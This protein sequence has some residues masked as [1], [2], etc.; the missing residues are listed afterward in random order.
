MRRWLWSAAAASG[1]LA[2]MVSCAPQ[3][4]PVPP[5]LPD[6]PWSRG[7]VLYGQ[8][9]AGC[10]GEDG[11]GSEDRPALAPLRRAPAAG[12]E[13]KTAFAT[14]ADLQAYVRANMP[15]LEAGS[16]SDDEAWALTTYLLRQADIA[17]PAELTAKNAAQ[18]KI[19]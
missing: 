4:D 17:A 15:P 7:V 6:D 3:W 13:R 16:L 12:S 5:K 1:A 19:P 8:K 11:E 10:H 9:C 14:A 2:A 18:V